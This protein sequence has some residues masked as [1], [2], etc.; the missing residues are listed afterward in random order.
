METIPIQHGLSFVISIA[1]LTNF[2]VKSKI[3]RTNSPRIWDTHM[4]L[5][6]EEISGDA[7]CHHMYMGRPGAHITPPYI[8]TRVTIVLN[9][10]TLVQGHGSGP[11]GLLF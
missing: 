8:M 11:R 10:Y 4:S 9:N 7:I 3:I 5:C 1:V 6:H 2:K